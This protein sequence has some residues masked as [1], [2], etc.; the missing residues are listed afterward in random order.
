MSSEFLN[1]VSTLVTYALWELFNALSAATLTLTGAAPTGSFRC[2]VTL[3]ASGTHIDCTG[4]VI[5]GSEVLTFLGAAKK[6]TTTYLTSLPVITTANLD[7]NIKIVATDVNGNDLQ[8]ETDT[9]I[10][11]DWDDSTT[12]YPNSAGGFTR[13]DSNCETDCLTAK[14]GD[15][16]V[17]NGKTVPVKNIKDGE[18]TLSGTVLSK[19][20][21][22]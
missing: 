12:Y 2:S 8:K 1:D 11:V 6:T 3:S 19:I 18:Q 14:I 22:F 10:A 7:C 13:S 9:T 5:V 4:T 15:P 17:H 21:Q 20:L 16:V